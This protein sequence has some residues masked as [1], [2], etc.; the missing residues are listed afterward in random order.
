MRCRKISGRTGLQ[1]LYGC[2]PPGQSY[3]KS[4]LFPK[5]KSSRKP[6]WKWGRFERGVNGISFR[7]KYFQS[8]RT[9][10]PLWCHG[11]KSLGR[12]QKGNEARVEVSPGALLLPDSRGFLGFPRTGNPKT[13][14]HGEG[15]AA[16]R[17][18]S[19]EGP[20]QYFS[21]CW[22]NRLVDGNINLKDGDQSSLFMN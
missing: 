22:S 18:K 11:K 6:P 21:K 4:F 1:A 14:P 10:R 3:C 15:V 5:S 13:Q 12:K 17:S 9:Q 19:C 8:S 7:A 20:E 2:P 16:E